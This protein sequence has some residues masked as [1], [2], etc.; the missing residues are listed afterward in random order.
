LETNTTPTTRGLS[1]LG[2][3]A[4]ALIKAG[5]PVFPLA[6]LAN[7]PR[8]NCRDC[9][10]DRCDHPP[11]QCPCPTN[12][13]PCH[14]FYAATR[15]PDLATH[16]WTRWPQANIG[17]PAGERTGLVIV[18]I[19]TAHPDETPP[20]PWNAV[21]GIS[22]GWDTLA[23]LAERAHA[24]LPWFDNVTVQTPSTGK[25]GARGCHIWFTWTGDPIPSSAGRIGW[26]V[27]IRANGG[28]A[29]A[30]PSRRAE[31]PYQR[32]NGRIIQPLPPW[33][34]SLAAPPPPPPRRAV[35]PPEPGNKGER[36]AAAALASAVTII[37][38]SGTRNVDLNAQAF[39]IG[40]L[41]GAGL[42]NHDYAEQALID[43]AT[44]AGLPHTEATYVTRRSLTQGARNPRQLAERTPQR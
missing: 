21:T 22:D 2:Q 11:Q 43:A 20:P 24:P 25:W 1:P 9:K 17:I 16:W 42:L 13:H 5:Y 36:Y 18:D 39:G 30:P 38:N 37:T 19:D 14:S 40:S 34:A 3:G 15:N 28:F 6:D 33:L 31:G 8:P 32:T 7:A 29:I 27:D 4:H 26:K 12:G 35:Q 41:V 44:D 10:H 23:A